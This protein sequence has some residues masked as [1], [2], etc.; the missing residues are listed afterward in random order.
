MS[1][2]KDLFVYGSSAGAFGTLVHLPAFDAAIPQDKKGVKRTL[3]VDSAAHFGVGT[4]W[5]K[6]TPEFREDFEKMLSGTVLK[7]D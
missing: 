4:F 2:V 5:S 6:F 1:K 3:I 7:V